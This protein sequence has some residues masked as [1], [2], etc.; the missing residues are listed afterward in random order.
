V[1]ENI[2]KQAFP[3]LSHDNELLFN[4]IYVYIASACNIVLNPNIE[5]ARKPL[6]RHFRKFKMIFLLIKI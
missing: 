2:A 1:I 3:T 4:D 6:E 5:C